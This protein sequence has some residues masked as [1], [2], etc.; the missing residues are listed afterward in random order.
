MLGKALEE[1][2]QALQIEPEYPFAEA[3]A[4]AIRKQIN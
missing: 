2:E 1:F 3:A 4:E